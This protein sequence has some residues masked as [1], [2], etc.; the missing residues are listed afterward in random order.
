MDLRECW[1][2]P[3]PLWDYVTWQLA[4]LAMLLVGVVARQCKGKAR[5]A[6]WPLVVLAAGCYL[7]VSEGVRRYGIWWPVGLTYGDRAIAPVTSRAADLCFL[8]AWYSTSLALTFCVRY[9]HRKATQRS[10][11]QAGA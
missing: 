6:G 9:L 4:G 10:E 3:Y 2:C 1:D 11:A 8:L 5:M 7:L